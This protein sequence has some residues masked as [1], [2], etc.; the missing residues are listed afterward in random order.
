MI[1]IN[2]ELIWYGKVLL[3]S[4]FLTFAAYNVIDGPVWAVGSGDTKPLS[5]MLGG[6]LEGIFGVIIMAF[7]FFLAARK[8]KPNH[9]QVATEYWE[10]AEALLSDQH[11][12][13]E[14]KKAIK[15][16]DQMRP[17]DALQDAA[18]LYNLQQIRAREA[19][20]K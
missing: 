12:R 8:I 5:D 9:R 6:R 2:K 11:T 4:F 3:V 16:L 20:K 1:K 15:F 17:I 14:L 19:R 13:P 10:A 18:V 7:I